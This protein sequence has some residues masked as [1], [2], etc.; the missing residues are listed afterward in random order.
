MVEASFGPIL[1]P[2]GA[3][4]GGAGFR[5]P[6]GLPD[7]AVVDAEAALVKDEGCVI[8]TS[9]EISLCYIDIRVHIK[10]I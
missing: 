8:L 9:C 5:L 3:G 7:P 6:D 4:G 2:L 1:G 10:G